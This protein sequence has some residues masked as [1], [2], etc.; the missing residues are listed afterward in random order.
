[1]ANSEKKILEYFALLKNKNTLRSS[2]LFI[3]ENFSTVNNIL[4]LISC[5]DSDKF[6]DICWDCQKINSGNHPDLTVVEPELNTIKIETIKEAQKTLYLKSFRLPKKILLVK[7]GD[8][9]PDAANS[10]LKSLE[11]PPKNSFIAICVTS[12]DKLIPTII[13]RCQKI[14]LPFGERKIEDYSLVNSFFAGEKIFFK[15]RGEFSSFLWTL[16][17]LF[18]D[19]IVTNFI[20]NE[21]CLVE[22]KQCKIALSQYNIEQAK[23]VLEEVINIYGVHQSVNENLALHLI[24]SKISSCA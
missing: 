18:R 22:N 8:W 16:I 24:K 6:C 2:Y 7:N 11:E 1:M 15:N 12:L 23:N 5:K 4:K 14:F 10:F 9:T 20:D 17:M 13:S 21:N 19:R 3:G